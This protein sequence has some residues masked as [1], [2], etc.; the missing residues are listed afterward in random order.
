MNQQFDLHNHPFEPV[1]VPFERFMR[2]FLMY[3][4]LY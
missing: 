3:F 2:P 4:I 1:N